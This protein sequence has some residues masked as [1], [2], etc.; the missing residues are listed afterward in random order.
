MAK[1]RARDI[2]RSVGSFEKM[3]K[4]MG[5]QSYQTEHGRLTSKGDETHLGGDR[6]IA[7][8][9]GHVAVRTDSTPDKFQGTQGIK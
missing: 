6:L 5:W 3:G 1:D 2:R 7:P 4:A 9:R 8:G